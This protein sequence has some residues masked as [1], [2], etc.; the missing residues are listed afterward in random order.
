MYASSGMSEIVNIYS[1]QTYICTCAM[2]RR[3][4]QKKY[5]KAYVIESSLLYTCC[6]T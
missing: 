6:T 4:I 2:N 5:F 1:D 3:V